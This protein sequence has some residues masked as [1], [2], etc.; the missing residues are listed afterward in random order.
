MLSI[1]SQNQ[2]T[3]CVNRWIP[4]WKITNCQRIINA[5]QTVRKHRNCPQI[6]WKK[7]PGNGLVITAL[8]TNLEKAFGTIDHQTLG[9]K[10][11]ALEISESCYSLLKNY[12]TDRQ[13]CVTNEGAVFNFLLCLICR[14]TMILVRAALVLLIC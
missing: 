6:S 2:R 3:L 14:S 4:T 7:A 9:I 13:Q 8:I 1:P 5:F 11:R 10:L 12:L